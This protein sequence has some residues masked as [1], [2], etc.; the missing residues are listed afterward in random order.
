MSSQF[1]FSDP[2]LYS[3]LLGYRT[4]QARPRSG[5]RFPHPNL[6]VLGNV[7]RCS[8][9][10]EDCAN[11]TPHRSQRYG[12]RKP[13][14]PS[15]QGDLSSRFIPPPPPYSVLPSPLC[16]NC[17]RTPLLKRIVSPFFN[18]QVLLTGDSGVG[19]SSVVPSSL[20]NFAL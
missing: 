8:E 17:L 7:R 10:K 4:R 19:K 11:M 5:K 9:R 20:I 6:N 16:S 13:L 1:R 3:N 2:V 14:R 18:P 12:R 15:L